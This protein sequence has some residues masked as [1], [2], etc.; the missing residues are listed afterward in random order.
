MTTVSSLNNTI[1]T[2]ITCLQNVIAGTREPELS[3]DIARIMKS[4]EGVSL[5]P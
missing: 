2:T 1:R 4:Y 5:T 3:V